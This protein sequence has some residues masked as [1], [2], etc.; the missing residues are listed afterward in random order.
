MLPKSNSNFMLMKKRYQILPYRTQGEWD[1]VMAIAQEEGVDI[2]RFWKRKITLLRE[3]CRQCPECVIKSK[4]KKVRKPIE[5]TEGQFVFF[6]DL[7][8]KMK[9]PV[10]SVVNELLISPILRREQ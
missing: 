1:A 3:K 6:H 5:L 7:A 9:K 10:T 8:K 4:G 2:N